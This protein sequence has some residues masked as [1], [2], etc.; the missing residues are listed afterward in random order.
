MMSI[1]PLPS[2]PALT[3][4]FLGAGNMASALSRGFA[5]SGLVAAGDIWF[6]DIVSEKAEELAARI[7]GQAARTIRPLMQACDTIILAVKPQNAAQLMP[8]VAPWAGPKHLFISILAGMPTAR[9]QAQI[10]GEPRIIRV[11]P[12]TPALVGLGASGV[13]RGDF[14]STDD[15]ELAL[16]LF[17]SAGVAVAVEESQIDAV[18]AISGSGP[19]YFF[20]L[21]EALME[22]AAELGLEQD[23]ARTLVLQTA[24]GAATLAVDS[25]DSP[26]T[27]RA[28]V[29]SKGGTTEAGLKVLS[30]GDW[31]G[32][33]RQCAQAAAKR[34][35]K[36]AKMG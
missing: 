14:A 25:P 27:L 12:N 30:D 19:A 17:R 9:L 3:I 35:A 4:G 33:V 32:L 34:A 8:D 23:T 18:T 1:P 15:L 24:L 6:Y 20:Y 2:S 7:G 26:A 29:T 10:G 21:M 28:N 31:A 5:R 13:A 11:M 22:A 16:S 36:L